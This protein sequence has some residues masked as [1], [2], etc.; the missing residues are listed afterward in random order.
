M[1]L[2]GNDSVRKYNDFNKACLFRI[3]RE[4]EASTYRKWLPF[5]SLQT[6]TNFKICLCACK[7]LNTLGTNTEVGKIQKQTG[8]HLRDQQS[9]GRK[10]FMIEVLWLISQN[11]VMYILS[12][13]LFFGC[14]LLAER[15]SRWTRKVGHAR[16]I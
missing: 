15:N 1:T 13:A 9:S 14:A 2:S 4:G 10:S 6:T 11:W 8:R 3:L 16:N 12:T 7:I 5:I